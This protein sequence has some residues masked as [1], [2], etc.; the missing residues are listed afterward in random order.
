MTFNRGWHLAGLVALLASLSS[1]YPKQIDGVYVFEKEAWKSTIVID[2]GG[3]FKQTVFRNGNP[4]KSI[5]GN[6]SR[7]NDYIEFVPFLTLTD[8]ATQDWRSQPKLLG[9]L[10]ATLRGR[11]IVFRETPLFSFKKVQ[12][13]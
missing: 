7:V 6:W 13:N 9:S 5:D 4:I 1:C 10:P 11:Y 12:E 8:S 2:E 3:T